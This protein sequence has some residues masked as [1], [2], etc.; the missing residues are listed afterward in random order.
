MAGI[1]NPMI[2]RRKQP[3]PLREQLR[4]AVETLDARGKFIVVELDEERISREFVDAIREDFAPYVEDSGAVGILV[5]PSWTK[6]KA[7]SRE[8]IEELGKK[9]KELVRD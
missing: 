3:P 8:D 4:A 2:E 7:L 6:V 5:M 1:R 9:I